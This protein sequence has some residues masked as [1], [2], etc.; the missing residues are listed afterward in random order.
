M[1]HTDTENYVTLLLIQDKLE[2]S[3]FQKC[4]EWTLDPKTI[5]EGRAL[6]A[7]KASE[8]FGNLSDEL[9]EDLVFAQRIGPVLGENLNGNPRQ[10][11][12]FLN[13]LIMR[14][15]MAKSREIVLNRRILAKLMLLEYFRSQFFRNLSAWQNIQEGKP[16]QLKKIS[17]EWLDKNPAEALSWIEERIAKVNEIPD[18]PP[19][20]HLWYDIYNPEYPE[21]QPERLTLAELELKKE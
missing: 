6:S 14:I 9:R 16:E 11:K 15:I 4:I 21:W 12:R 5:Q 10:C 2:D 3:K 20:V 7:A 19:L 13:T 17:L 8:L 1:T 18:Y